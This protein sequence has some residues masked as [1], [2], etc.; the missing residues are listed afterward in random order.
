VKIKSEFSF[1]GAEGPRNF[2]LLI[3]M[4][5]IGFMLCFWKWYWDVELAKMKKKD[6]KK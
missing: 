6:V 3:R 5:R 2:G 4:N 1:Y